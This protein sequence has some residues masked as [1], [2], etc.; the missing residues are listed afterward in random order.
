MDVKVIDVKTNLKELLRD[1][2]VESLLELLKKAL[3]GRPKPEPV[4]RA[5][6]E[7]L[8][9]KLGG[10]SD[11]ML[12]VRGRVVDAIELSS[13]P[14]VVSLC[15]QAH[16]Y[17]ST[18]G[19]SLSSTIELL[20]H[21]VNKLTHDEECACV[22]KATETPTEAPPPDTSTVPE[23]AVGGSDGNATGVQATAE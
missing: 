6:L 16:S 17:I 3:T 12:R 23:P 19:Q 18:T 8:S 9:K 5:E 10:F 15:A 14:F 11:E 22:T 2:G 4:T 13:D 21:V 1:N 7:G 20:D